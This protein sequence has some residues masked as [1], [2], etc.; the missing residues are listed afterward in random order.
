M[1]RM[2]DPVIGDFEMNNHVVEYEPGR[3]IG[4]EPENGLGHPDAG[5]PGTGRWRRWSFELTPD[6]PDATVVTE[7]Y[8]CCGAPEEVRAELECG[9]GASEAGTCYIRGKM[10]GT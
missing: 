4:W 10:T 7:S 8:D 3:R 1:M 2:H 6:G 5:P 9:N